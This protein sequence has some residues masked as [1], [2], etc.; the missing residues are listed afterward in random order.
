MSS[1]NNSLEHTGK[2]CDFFGKFGS[3][4]LTNRL[5][6]SSKVI[7]RYYESTVLDPENNCIE[8]TV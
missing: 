2:V 7:E 4:N 8:V 1:A 6:L 5:L 3:K